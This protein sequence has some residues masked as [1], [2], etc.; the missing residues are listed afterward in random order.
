MFP[1]YTNT[2]PYTYPM[3][4]SGVDLQGGSGSIQIGSSTPSM[5]G[6]AVTIQGPNVNPTYTQGTGTQLGESTTNSYYDPAA[7]AAAAAA[8]KQQS[9]DLA[10]LDDQEG[11]LKGML[12]SSQNTLNNGLTQIGDT[13]DKEVGRTNDSKTAATQKFGTQRE[14][15]TR[16]MTGARGTA[17]AQARSLADSVR[18]VLGIASGVNSSAY[19]EAAPG[20][21]ATDTT[22]KRGKIDQTF[23]KNFRN[24][25]TAEDSTTT[26]FEKYLTDLADQRNQKESSLRENVLQAEQ[27]IYNNLSEVARQRELVKGGGYDQ[28]REATAPMRTEIANRQTA[29]DGLF[30]QFRT[31]YQTKDVA[32][33]SP[34]LSAYVVDNTAISKGGGGTPSVDGSIYQQYAKKRFSGGQV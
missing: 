32:A 23:A 10:Y 28:V 11:L 18:R 25:K 34:E 26:E 1:N 29:I 9:D 27:G 15:T 5:S 14:D 33:A 24:I 21:I 7:A 17:N 4:S 8:A 6:G 22:E 12:T 13:Y 20:M 2:N 16:D 31:P 19:K 3:Q 30:N